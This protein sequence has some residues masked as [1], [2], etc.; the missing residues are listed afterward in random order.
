[1]A[2]LAR[3]YSAAC[4]S[5]INGRQSLFVTNLHLILKSKNT[6]RQIIK[7]KKKPTVRIKHLP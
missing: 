5:I 1:M 3:K 2:P 4:T 6:S 7:D